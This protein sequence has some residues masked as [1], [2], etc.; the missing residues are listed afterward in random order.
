MVVWKMNIQ[1]DKKIA[2][3]LIIYVYF[4]ENMN[5]NIVENIIFKILKFITIISNSMEI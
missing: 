3:M 1:N 5:K 4:V 2:L